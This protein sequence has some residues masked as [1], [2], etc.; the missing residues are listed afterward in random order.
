MARKKIAKSSRPASD[1]SGELPRFKRIKGQIDGVEK[2]IIEKRYCGEILDQLRAVKSG[3]VAIEASILETHL[4]TCVSEAIK[5]GKQ[6]EAKEKIDEV[7]D[8]FRHATRKGILL[9]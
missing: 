9:T 1:H 2:M 6:K 3:L 5:S 7:I 4:H 8:L